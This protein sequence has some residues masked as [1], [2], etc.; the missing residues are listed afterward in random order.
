MNMSVSM[1]MTAE[2]TM[3]LWSILLY[4][5][6]IIV[7]ATLAIVENGLMAQ[8]GARDNLPEPSV[9]LARLKRLASNMQE[10][11][12]LFA[13]LVLLAHAAGVHSDYTVLGAQLFFWARVAHAVIYIAGWPMVRPLAWFVGVIG[14]GMIAV[15]MF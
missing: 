8:G 1:G 15:A 6:L 13:A 5:V 2:L 7:P 3:L 10:N 9:L 12:V 11:M 4:F 14:M